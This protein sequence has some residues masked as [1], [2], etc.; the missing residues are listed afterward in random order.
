MRVWGITDTKFDIVV[1]HL[2][3]TLKK[4]KI[5]EREHDEVTAKIGN[6]RSYI[7]EWKK[8]KIDRVIRIVACL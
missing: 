5:P 6:L 8:L 1:N 2:A 3:A 4:S 7:V